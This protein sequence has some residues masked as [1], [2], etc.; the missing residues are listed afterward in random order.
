MDQ[1]NKNG[2]SGTAA[3]LV[4]SKKNVSKSIVNQIAASASGLIGNSILRPSPYAA[5]SS[6][7]SIT[8]DGNKGTFAS[9]STD[10][11][12][13][14]SSSR[15]PSSQCFSIHDEQH[16]CKRAAEP[17][18]SRLRKDGS[19]R[20]D[21]QFG[22]EDFASV[23]EGFHLQ[24]HR[25]SYASLDAQLDKPSHCLSNTC[26][27]DGTYYALGP[28]EIASLWTQGSVRPSTS[29]CVDGAAVVTLLSDPEFSPVWE[30]EYP[31]SSPQN[32]IDEIS[33]ET[34]RFRP[35]LDSHKKQAVPFLDNMNRHS[36][37]GL[38]SP[39]TTTREF[40]GEENCRDS[41][42]YDRD[43]DDSRLRSWLDKF[44]TYQDEVW[45]YMSPMVRRA[46]AE[47]GSYGA[48]T[49]QTAVQR[50]AMIL[51]HINPIPKRS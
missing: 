15:L 50:L 10:P 33:D 27:K 22:F 51:R 3:L 21:V 24:P 4:E 17:Q 40:L 42:S 13:L 49:E 37:I 32:P 20:N 5:I 28:T 7:A 34:S 45:G 9:A 11:S 41:E 35:L 23:Y 14:G 2:R 30:L 1:I 25:H 36:N 31:V 26:T 39:S 48:L 47:E 44:K 12:G 19:H 29:V 43:Q 16:D 38:E 46:R 6:L 8:G 18:C